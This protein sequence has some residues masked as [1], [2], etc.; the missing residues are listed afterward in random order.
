MNIDQSGL[1][2]TW[3]LGC[4]VVQDNFHNKSPIGKIESSIRLIKAEASPPRSR[5]PSFGL[6]P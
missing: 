2:M 6:L 3:N 4:D 1:H 5:V